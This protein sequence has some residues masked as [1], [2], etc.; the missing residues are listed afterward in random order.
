M[1]LAHSFTRAANRN[2]G[3]PFHT[4]AAS[5]H[6]GVITLLLSVRSDGLM[7][8]DRF[9]ETPAH[10]AVH[11]QRLNMTRKMLQW[12]TMMFS[13]S[14]NNYGQTPFHLAVVYEQAAMV[15]MMVDIHEVGFDV[16]D[17]K[18]KTARQLA[19]NTHAAVRSML[20]R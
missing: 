2:R 5:G 9:G 15:R 1:A 14:K 13:D 20:W 8:R 4:A 12:D 3:T 7:D 10:D 11:N 18:G 16:P 17:G 6:V 19:E